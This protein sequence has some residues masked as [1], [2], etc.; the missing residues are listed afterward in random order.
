MEH[1]NTENFNARLAALERELACYYGGLA[2]LLEECFAKGAGVRALGLTERQG[3]VRL[4]S[5]VDVKV[6]AIGR[7]L[8]VWIRYAYEGVVSAGYGSNAM[9][10]HAEGSLERLRDMLHLLRKDDPYFELCLDA[11]QSDMSDAVSFGGL[12]DLSARVTARHELDIGLDLTPQQLALLANM[13]ERSVRNAMLGS[14]DLKANA[15]GMIDNAEAARWLKGRRG[16]VLSTRRQFPSDSLQIPDALDYV[17]IPPFIRLRLRTLWSSSEGN[18][19]SKSDP[20]YPEWV[21]E[22]SRHSG[23]SPAQILESCELP[24]AVRPHECGQWAIALQVDRVWFTHQ[25]MSA[26]FPEQ[27][28]MLLNPGAWQPAKQ[29]E[30]PDQAI[31]T[32]TITLS[33]AMLLHGYLDM[34]SSATAMFPADSLGTRNEGDTGTSVFLEYGTHRSETDIRV[35]S[36]KTISPR[37]RFGAWLNEELNA[38]VGDRIRIERIGDRQYK[39]SH[40]TG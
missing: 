1:A 32:I 18:A 39:L 40:I 34:P 24:L 23:L 37:K 16:F 31:T 33:Q 13:S 30:V 25:I 28:D 15:N 2:V 3:Y 35:K 19:P 12:E 14:G 22:A 29:S 5:S 6:T 27:V 17:E 36:A 7:M 9:D 21:V 8:P 38:R 11:A 20:R 26:L 4:A 10:T